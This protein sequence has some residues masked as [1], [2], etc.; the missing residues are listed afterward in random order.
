MTF[1]IFLAQGGFTSTMS[2]ARRNWYIVGMVCLTLLTLVLSGR[3]SKPEP[4]AVIESRK[5]ERKEYL[6]QLQDTTGKMI[7]RMKELATIAGQLPLETYFDKYLKLNKM[8]PYIYRTLKRQK[9]EVVRRKVATIVSLHSLNFGMN[10]V[11]LS[12]LQD[13]DDKAGIGMI[14]LQKEYNEYYP[15][16]RDKKLSAEL[17]ILFKYA[18]WFYSC[19]AL[20]ELAKNSDFPLKAPKYISPFYDKPK[21]LEAK[22][23]KQQRKV[24]DRF[25]DL[26]REGVPDE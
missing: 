3:K 14:P 11:Y 24:N 9:D 22:L 13:K 20:A 23:L 21:K 6:P 1:I 12:E 26:L 8:Y 7:V 5:K 10:N 19:Y 17:D 15:R 25:S 16:N 2:D 4:Q 18:K